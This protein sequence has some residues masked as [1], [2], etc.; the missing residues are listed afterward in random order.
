MVRAVWSEELNKWFFSVLDIIGAIND[1]DDY[2]KNRNYWKYLKAKLRKEQNELVS[3]TTQLKFRAADDK[4]YLSD[5]IDQVN[6]YEWND[7]LSCDDNLSELFNA[8]NTLQIDTYYALVAQRE[9]DEQAMGNEA[10]TGD[11]LQVTEKI[12]RD[13]HLYILRDGKTYSIMGAEVK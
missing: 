8:F 10:V 11:G 3:A 4:L 7:A 2:Q 5:A 6:L 12:L 1:Q 9:I 13:G